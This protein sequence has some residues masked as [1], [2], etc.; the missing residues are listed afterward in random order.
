MDDPWRLSFAK[1]VGPVS[2]SLICTITRP[3]V[4]RRFE[5]IHTLS[6]SIGGSTKGY[7]KEGSNRGSRWMNDDVGRMVLTISVSVLYPSLFLVGISF[8]VCLTT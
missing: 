5:V 3:W 2:L 6:A 8:C 7:C 1:P 4:F